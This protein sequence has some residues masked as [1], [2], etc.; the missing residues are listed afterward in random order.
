MSLSSS[1]LKMLERV[2]RKKIGMTDADD[3]A[4][5]IVKRQDDHERRLQLVEAALAPKVTNAGT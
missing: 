4:L 3:A 5:V 2:R 1:D